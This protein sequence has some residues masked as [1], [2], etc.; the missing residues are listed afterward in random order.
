MANKIPDVNEMLGE[1]NAGVFMNQ[2]EEVLKDTAKAVINFGD[3]GKKGKV[4]ITLTMTRLGE[5]SGMVDLEHKWA[6][7]QPEMR[8]KATRD[9]TSSTPMCVSSRGHLT[10]YP[11]SQEDLFE[12]VGKS[13][14][15]K[16][17]GGK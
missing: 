7:E 1:L 10:V 3:K 11:L 14:V 5:D 17:E 8:G 4:T 15:A 12:V 9:N 6:Y 13:N 2:L 16:F